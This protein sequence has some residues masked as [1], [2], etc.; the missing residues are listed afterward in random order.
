[1]S[2]IK[3]DATGRG[4]WGRICLVDLSSRTIEYE[5]VNDDVYSRFLSGAGLGA[6]VLWD[7]MTPRC[8]PLGP[9]NILG[10]ATGL[11]TD[12]GSLFTGR[13]TVVGKSPASRGWGDANCGGYFSPLLKRCRVDALFFQ[14]ISERPVYL[15]IADKSA[16]LKDATDLWGKDTIET[17]TLLKDRHGK[18]AQ[19]ACIGPAGERL[20]YISGISTHFGRMAAR[21]GLGAVMGSKKLKAVVAFGKAGV[22]VADRD[23]IKELAEQFKA[24]YR[25]YD[26]AKG[27]LGDRFFSLAGRITGKGGLF[28]RQPAVVWRLMLR[29][30]GT[31]SLTAMSAESGDSPIKNWNGT[32]LNDFPAKSYKKIGAGEFVKYETKKYGCCSCPLRCGATATVSDG[33]YK[34]DKMHR[35]EYETICAFGDLLLNDDIHSIFKLTDMVNRAGMDS[36]SCGS[37]LAFAIESFVEGVIDKNDTD[38]LELAWGKSEAL[39]DLTRMIINREGIGDILADG[40]KVAAQKLGRGSEK[41]A[42]QCGGI[43]APMH[44]AKFDPGL[45]IA[46]QCEP[47]PGRH[48]VSC[49]QFLDIQFLEKQF[50]RAKKIPLIY[51]RKQKYDPQDKGEAVAVGSFYKMLVDGAGDCLFGTQTGGGFPLCEWLNA[52]TGWDPTHDEYLLIGE[53]IEQLRHAFNI[54]EGLNPLRDFRPHPRIYGETPLSGGP[55]KGVQLDLERL[56]LSFYRALHWDPATGLPDVS[57]M[58]RLGLRE[59]IEAFFGQK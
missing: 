8:D 39:I 29:K 10:F 17:E 47:T 44:D 28:I 9:D 41:Y 4:F 58:E 50:S 21:S 57:H 30:F 5:D 36:I 24:R 40:V 54:R 23:R 51:T 13:F 52:A 1:M 7:R 46:Y 49:L 2:E 16:E 25:R 53:R 27:I 34:I 12:T 32:A 38:G 59:V 43:E 33:P 37:V 15:Y 22:E 45:G 6:K 19:I 42:V 48:S 14:G 56:A 18:G 26:S 20:S 31:P 11:L 55:L 35:P 3:D